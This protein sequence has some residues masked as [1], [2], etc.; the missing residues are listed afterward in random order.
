M[1]L[2]CYIEAE[3][4]AK[5]EHRQ[6][7]T[8]LIEAKSGGRRAKG[9]ERR[10]ESPGSRVSSLGLPVAEFSNPFKFNYS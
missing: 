8:L 6:M 4:E 9:G 1:L 7:V 5:E 2:H 10:I 3:A